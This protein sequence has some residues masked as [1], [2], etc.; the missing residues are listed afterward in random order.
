MLTTIL[1]SIVG[2]G[3]SL[4]P[5]ALDYFK[6][7]EENKHQ[8]EMRSLD[9]KQELVI[10][11]KQKEM[12]E[13]EHKFAVEE[14]H[15]R[16]DEADM[17]ADARMNEAVINSGSKQLINT[18]SKIINFINALN[19]SVRPIIAYLLIAFFIFVHTCPF[20]LDGATVAMVNLIYTPEVHALIIC[21]ITYFFGNRSL[22][23]LDEKRK[24]Y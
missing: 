19:A 21:V 9:Y 6:S 16:F 23:Y 17:L 4:L 10:L 14:A 1:S 22:K 20:F 3:G 12:K 7:K 11:D 24:R 8:I 13:S 15:L 18:D 5:S 2:L